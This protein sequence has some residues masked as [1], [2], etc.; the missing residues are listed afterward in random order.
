[1]DA[2]ACQRCGT[3]VPDLG[4]SERLV[5]EPCFER[6]AKAGRYWSANYLKGVGVLL[7]PTVAMVLL[8]LN[9][10]RLGE[11]RAARQWAVGAAAVAGV[12]VMFMLSSLKVGNSL[13]LGAGVT[14]GLAVGRQWEEQWKQL[15][16]MG[17]GR[18]N[19]WL[20][21][22][23]TVMVLIGFVAVATLLEVVS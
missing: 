23:V 4:L 22:V 3:F 9:L 2:V 20:P 6:L 8:A 16:A 18:A 14:G 7:N 12:Y 17:A 19:G 11:K 1:M 15:A 13:V 5:C 21:P 10:A